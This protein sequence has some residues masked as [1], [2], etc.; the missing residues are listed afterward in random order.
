MIMRHSFFQSTKL[1]WLLLP[2]AF[3]PL[4]L[5]S[6]EPRTWSSVGRGWPWHYGWQFTDRGTSPTP[7]IESLPAFFADFLFGLTIVVIL[8]QTAKYLWGKRHT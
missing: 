8:R 6:R 5:A 1:F 7:K 4:F 3:L 2:F